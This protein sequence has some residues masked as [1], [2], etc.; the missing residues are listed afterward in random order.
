MKLTIIVA[1]DRNGV[2][3]KGDGLP[4]PKIPE[5]MTLFRKLT[6]G[7]P[8]IAGYKTYFSLPVTLNGRWPVILTRNQKLKPGTFQS[9][10][11]STAEVKR[12]MDDPFNPFSEAFVIGG[13]QAYSA[14]ADLCSEAH[15][16]RIDR[17]Y[18]GDVVFPFPFLESEWAAVL[19]ETIA[20]GVTHHHY[21][22][23]SL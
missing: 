12:M 9:I 3:G 16:T 1:M 23:R 17:D 7:K 11:R 13:A 6:M 18:D 5:D 10:V 22:R 4:W 19:T 14:L 21:I 20:A 8:I 2:I 15:V